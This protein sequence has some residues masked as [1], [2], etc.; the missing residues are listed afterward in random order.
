MGRLVLVHGSNLNTVGPSSM[1]TSGSSS[2]GQRPPSYLLG[3]DITRRKRRSL[4]VPLIIALSSALLGVVYASNP[5]LEFLITVG[6]LQI[7]TIDAPN[8]VSD[9]KK[10]RSNAN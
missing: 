4:V 9:P 7:A 2:G 1:N 3:D 6:R 5:R 10:G 8:L